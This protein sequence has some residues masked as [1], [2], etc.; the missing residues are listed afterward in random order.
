M[1]LTDLQWMEHPQPLPR[2][3]Q[4]FLRGVSFS[5]QAGQFS[6]GN[7]VLLKIWSCTSSSLEHKMKCIHPSVTLS[8]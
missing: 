8:I 1:V 5:S 2:L 6:T 3:S 7:A 4:G